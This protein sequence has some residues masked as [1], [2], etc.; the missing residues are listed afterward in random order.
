MRSI[1]STG[2]CIYL[3]AAL[4]A[5][6]EQL[7]DAEQDNR[8]IVLFADAGDA[9]RP[10]DY[11]QFVPELVAAGITVSVIGL[12][13]ETDSDAQLLQEI[14]TLGLGRCQF[15]KDATDL[16][17]VFAQETIQVARSSLIEETTEVLVQPTL[18]LLGAMPDE[19]PALG[20]YAV[21]WSRPRAE[22]D[23]A[24]VR[25]G[26][27][28]GA[29]SG[30]SSGASSEPPEPLLA[31]WQIGLGRSAAFLGEA[32]GALSGAWAEWPGYA[33][34]FGTLVRWLA[35]G[36]PA[37]LFVDARR[38]GDVAV[39]QLEVDAK[40]ATVLDAVR[41]V[42]TEP[43]GATSEL[44]FTSIANGRVEVRVPLV[45]EGV[46]RAAVQIGGDT[47]RLPPMCLPYSAEWQLQLDPQAGE[48]ILRDLARPTA[49]NVAPTVAAVLSG[50]RRSLLPRDLA[51]WFA[52]VAL[53]V[54]LVEIAVR[55]LQVQWQG[56]ARRSKVART[57]AAASDG[58]PTQADGA[59]RPAAKQPDAAKQPE[60]GDSLLSALE[61]AHKRGSRR[62]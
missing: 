61:R 22:L 56:S 37:G 1:E 48:R 31:H 25:K 17:R 14:A 21:A 16:P 6:H 19:L 54:L 60:H 7:A 28:S 40:N 27:G 44:L 23:L 4:H 52:I 18:Q 35:G 39:Y 51:P 57:V 33:D 13:K 45:A 5:A 62:V 42:V 43:D 30:A 8:H 15:V 49:G 47:V 59:Q 41:G 26:A 12:G 36:T 55:R 3:G 2:G 11:L 9:E 38:D 34:F 24:A 58:A 29:G 10:D 50:P 20:G 46:H 53:L 32:D